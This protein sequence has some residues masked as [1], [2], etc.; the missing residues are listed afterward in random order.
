MDEGVYVEFVKETM[1]C[2][3]YDMNTGKLLWTTE[4]RENA[5][6]MYGLS[7]IIAYGKLFVSAYDGRIYCYDIKNGEK[8]WEYFSGSSGTET[9]YGHWPFYGSGAMTVADNILF[10]ANDEHS[11]NS[12]LYKGATIT[13]I[14][15]T[16]DKEYGT[17]SGWMQGTAIADGYLVSL[18]GYDNALYCFGKGQTATT[19]TVSPKVSAKGTPVLIEALLPTSH[20]VLKALPQYLTKT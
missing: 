10:A 2:Y 5:W 1:T 12:P 15:V 13:A 17:I 6:G 11:P 9:I 16:T 19:V 20:Q 14:N 3:G 7:G 4:P 8:L 18:N